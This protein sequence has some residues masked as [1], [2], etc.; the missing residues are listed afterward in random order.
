MIRTDFMSVMEELDR[1]TE[2]SINPDDANIVD[3]VE[4]KHSYCHFL[5]PQLRKLNYYCNV[6]KKPANYIKAIIRNIL[7]NPECRITEK[8]RTFLNEISQHVDSGE[9]YRYVKNSI[10]KAHKTLVYVDDN[11]ELI[12]ELNDYYV[13][14][15]IAESLVETKEK[16]PYGYGPYKTPEDPT[17]Q[18]GDYIKA[19]RY[20]TDEKWYPARVTEITPDFVS[21][22]ISGWGFE[23]NGTALRSAKAKRAFG[24]LKQHLAKL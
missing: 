21:Y 12:P 14:F 6:E 16:D 3:Y 1:I 8:E 22:K 23:K 10:T 24:N 9:L 13:D 7:K 15:P 4:Y 5:E 2:A 18:V 19:K 20:S 17:L 11:G